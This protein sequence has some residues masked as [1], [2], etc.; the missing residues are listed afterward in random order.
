MHDGNVFH[1]TQWLF[2]FVLGINST[3]SSWPTT[4]KVYSM[5]FFWSWLLSF[6]YALLCSF[7]W[8]CYSA[9]PWKLKTGT[10]YISKGAVWVVDILDVDEHGVIISPKTAYH[11]ALTKVLESNYGAFVFHY[12][13]MWLLMPMALLAALCP[14]P[15]GKLPGRAIKPPW[16][17]VSVDIHQ[18][19]I[20]NYVEVSCLPHPN[21]P[22]NTPDC[23]MPAEI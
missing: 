17:K 9:T 22:F 12:E 21:F 3:S 5:V 18:G 14:G 11:N 20:A 23:L 8:Q 4:V 19:L 6:W 16:N 15:S 1:Y 2:N 10:P 13:H 7:S